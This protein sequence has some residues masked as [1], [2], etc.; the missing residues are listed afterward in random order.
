MIHILTILVF[1]S[2]VLRDS[3]RPPLLDWLTPGEIAAITL[4]PLAALA[5]FAE[6]GARLLMRRLDARSDTRVILWIDWLLASVRWCA[7]LWHAVCVLGAGWLDAVRSVL[8]A[9]LVLDQF[10]AALPA[11]LVIVLSWWSAYPLE[12]RLREAALV[13][14]LD[15][16]RPIHALPARGAFVW[17]QVRHQ[18]LLVMVP[19]L[20][21]S[22]WSQ[23]LTRFIPW[24][25]TA[26]GEHP[27]LAPAGDWLASPDHADLA[28]VGLQLI[29][30]ACLF[31]L[32]PLILRRLWDTSPLAAGPARDA[33]DALCARHGVR[34]SA[35]LVWRTRG[36]LINAMVMGLLPRLRYVLLTDA[37]LE[38]LPDR[39]VEAVLAHE[40]GHV[41]RRHMPWLAAGLIACV[42]LS[43]AAADLLARWIWSADP[44]PW[45]GGVA[46]LA[47]AAIGLAAGL[48]AFGWVSRRFEWQA[49]AFAAAHLSGASTA[50]R[51][52]AAAAPPA[53]PAPAVAADG[54]EAMIDA[55]HAVARLNHIPLDEFSWRHGSMRR[56]IA[57]L[58]ALVGQS[59]DRLRPDRT[60]RAV[61]AAIALGCAAILALA[62]L[63]P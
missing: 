8:P 2:L 9:G 39:Q 56:R 54:A 41:R 49:D 26:L 7:V 32:M 50:R 16:G 18:L 25:S 48:A 6:A 28:R 37:L 55:L 4:V 1:A 36:V 27:A 63:E 12:R 47:L 51:A 44:P 13:R 24:A 38:N 17:M 20:V 11:L 30:A 14:W 33:L 62:F 59:A 22:A 58:H 3:L 10:V 53:P 43:A 57:N 46:Q 31:A 45:L 40:V 52:A 29:G 19:M 23:G 5:V 15:E 34:V 21:L 61:K 42:G 60:A 35:A